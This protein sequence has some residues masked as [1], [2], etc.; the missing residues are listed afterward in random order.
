MPKNYFDELI[1]KSRDKGY[2]KIV[3]HQM[4]DPHNEHS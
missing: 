3:Q 4:R 1:K 2:H